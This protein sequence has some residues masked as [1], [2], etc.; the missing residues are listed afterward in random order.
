MKPELLIETERL[1]LRLVSEDDAD[2]IL[3]MYNQPKFIEHIGD[4]NIRTVEDA[5][6]Y[7]VSRFL[8]QAERLGY[9]NFAIIRKS[10][11]EKLG[12]VGIFERQGLDVHDIGFSLLPQFENHGYAFEAAKKLLDTAFA[13]W[14][15]K[16]VSAITSQTNF[17]SQKLIEKLG[18]IYQKDVTL[19][20]EDELLKYYELENLV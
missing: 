13:N 12:A 18:L 5:Q 14:N 3:E 9:G 8:P 20:G 2:L 10:D 4:K 11:G 16:K 1:Q 17:S 7:I 6:E 15:L 19:P